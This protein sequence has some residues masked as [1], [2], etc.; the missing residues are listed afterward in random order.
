[1]ELS[2]SVLIVFGAVTFG[3][4]LTYLA[5]AG[6][7]GQEARRVRQRVA[8]EFGPA[9]DAGPRS[10]LFRDLP[11]DA[12]HTGDPEAPAASRSVSFAGRLCTLLARADL[13]WSVRTLLL[14]SL[15]LGAALG[16]VGFLWN[17]PLLGVPAATAG[18]VAPLLYVSRRATA[19]REAMLSKL[20]AAF[21]LMARVIRAGQ[22]VTQA[23]QAVSDSFTGPL[24]HAF[25]DCQK[26]QSLGQR[27]EI[28]YRE[29]AE[30]TGILEMRIFVMAML[31][32]RQ[33]GGNLSDV[34]E[35][36]ATLVR[37]RL[38][39]RKQVRTL[40]AEGRLQ[41]WALAVLPAVVF[42]GLMILHREYAE[43][44]LQH[45]ILLIGAALSTLLGLLWIRTIV[46]FD[47]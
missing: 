37:T 2:L 34:L 16:V 17:G 33:A 8:Q 12:L 45:P 47:A 26:R 4:V 9:P 31:I 24:A 3:I 46:N 38:N 39:L 32:H 11:A 6:V 20:P 28:T 1:M 14:A 44:L 21:E 41:G 19:R 18:L 36:L 42:A 7:W 40:T 15:G 30:R 23:L 43:V 5:L 10:P 27:P 13:A 25:A 22:S 29:M 35:R